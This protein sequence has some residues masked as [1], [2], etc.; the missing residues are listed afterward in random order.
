MCLFVTKIILSDY[1]C[2]VASM[3][4]TV[5][6]TLNLYF[7]IVLEYCHYIITFNCF[8]ELWSGRSSV[9][10]TCNIS[11][12]LSV[13]MCEIWMYEWDAVRFWERT[14]TVSGRESFKWNLTFSWHLLKQADWKRHSSFWQRSSK[15]LWALNCRCP[16]LELRRCSQRPSWSGLLFPQC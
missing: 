2:T 16:L 15:D 6:H 5:S 14:T 8:K 1:Y 7:Y 12:G 11:K 3:H 13:N 4:F 10:W 9:T